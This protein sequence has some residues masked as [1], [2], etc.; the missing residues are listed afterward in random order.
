MA[1]DRYGLIGGLIVDRPVVVSLI[2]AFGLTALAVASIANPDAPLPAS[3]SI[4]ELIIAILAYSTLPPLL[5]ATAPRTIGFS[6]L[7]VVF[8]WALFVLVPIFAP[9]ASIA[10]TGY[11]LKAGSTLS[12]LTTLLILSGPA[13]GATIRFAFIASAAAALGM[14]GAMGMMEI[15]RVGGGVTGP[16]A[17]IGFAL[18]AFVGIGAAADFS[19]LFARGADTKRA[20]GVAA[21][22][23]LAP[24]IYAAILA[25]GAFSLND[26]FP[27]ASI[28]A[29][30]LAAA[31]GA[32]ALLASAAALFATAGALSL[33]RSLET[34]AVTENK[35]QQGFRKFWRPVRRLL[36]PSSAMAFAAILG[37][38]TIAAAFNLSSAVP[39]NQLAYFVV[40]A[41]AAS[42]VFLSLRTGVFI[43][44]LLATGSVLLA[45]FWDAMRAPALTER[46]IMATTALAAA[47]FAQLAVAWRDARNP[48]LNA[49]EVTEIAV[50]D[51]VPLFLVSVIIG[52]ASLLGA[53]AAGLWPSGAAASARF[54]M[55]AVYG[56]I[57]AP[58]LMTTLSRS[59]RRDHA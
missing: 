47:L 53:N 55:L 29:V 36:P 6:L 1:L 45:W 21:R 3:A 38:A 8:V 33:R 10:P 9:S 32:A 42:L 54:L 44:V 25:A 16:L 31:G 48:R 35:R 58:A 49:R 50:S 24:A 28:A 56:L 19:M 13:V 59:S 34:L 26:L 7:F 17:T 30:P 20:A 18:G 2:L 46:D 22:Y 14:A 41:G 43:L 15:E 57:A 51:A 37:V 23:G 27:Q 40:A 12:A 39:L 5:A 52:A 4:P 11:S